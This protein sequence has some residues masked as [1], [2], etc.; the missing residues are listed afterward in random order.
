MTRFWVGLILAGGRAQRN[1]RTILAYACTGSC[2]LG[3]S[4]ERRSARM[5]NLNR[6]GPPSRVARGVSRRC[7]GGY[8]HRIQEKFSLRSSSD[9]FQCHPIWAKAWSG[10]IVS[11]RTNLIGWSHS[12]ISLAL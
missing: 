4:S 3:V 6:M 10:R 12:N 2:R 8:P 9:R 11:R 7:G 1:L 5:R